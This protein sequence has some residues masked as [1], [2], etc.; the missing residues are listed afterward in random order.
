MDYLYH[1][2]SNETCFSILKNKNI[3]LSDIQ[4]SNDSMELSLFFPDLIFT[5]ESEYRQNPFPFKYKNETNESGFLL[6][7]HGSY[8][9]WQDQFKNGSF[10][11]F[12]IC[13]SEFNDMLSQ[14]RGYANDGKGCC[15]GFSFSSIEQYI[16][17]NEKVMELAKVQYI[18]KI[19]KDAMIHAAA[20][21]CLDNVATL[22]EWI[23]ENITHDDDSPDTDGLLQYNF[24]GML[25]AIFIDSLRYK[26]VSFSEE[27]EWR[28]FLRRP[29]YKNPEWIC[30]KNDAPLLGPDGFSETVE[31]LR[32]SIEF[33]ITNNDI[34]PFIPI[35]FADFNKHP[36][37]EIWTGPKNNIRDSDLRLYLSQNGYQDVKLFH[38]QITYR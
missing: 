28:I 13:F 21:K 23:V 2:C 17:A 19:E 31:F 14:W 30:R 24:D 3:R 22:R 18:S 12:V 38:S 26:S 8:Y 27:N 7:L 32:N 6:M 16:N 5:I 4:K 11:N 33:R 37:A 10:S 25:E 15:I 34:I 36:I 9:Y 20:R 29:A 35:H 1:Y